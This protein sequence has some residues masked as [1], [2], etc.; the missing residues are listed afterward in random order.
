MKSNTYGYAII[1]LTVKN[2]NN[3]KLEKNSSTTYIYVLITF[4]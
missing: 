2:C 4:S 1:Y 3:K